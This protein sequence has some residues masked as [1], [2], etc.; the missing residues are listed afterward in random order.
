MNLEAA[1]SIRWVVPYGRTENDDTLYRSHGSLFGGAAEARWRLGHWTVG[2]AG[3]LASGSLDV[4]EH[5]TPASVDRTSARRAAR[6]RRPSLSSPGAVRSFGSV[7]FERQRLPFVALAVLAGESAALAV[8]DLTPMR[9]S[10]TRLRH[11]FAT[12]SGARGPRMGYGQETVTITDAAGRSS[13]RPPAPA[14][15]S[16]AG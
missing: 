3:D 5:S 8:A 11:A 16:A 9:C 4:D 1:A 15:I 2:V 14:R 10:G 7:G 6:V 12:P 13:R